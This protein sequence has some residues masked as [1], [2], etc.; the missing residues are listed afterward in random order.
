MG[1]S[2]VLD[3]YQHKD[4]YMKKLLVCLGISFALVACSPGATQ[5]AENS[6]QP[7]EATGTAQPVAVAA[8]DKPDSGKT[9]SDDANTAKLIDPSL[10]NET[11]PLT[12]HVLV[13]TT[14]G[15]MRFKIDRTWAPHGVDRFYN[16][17]KNGYFTDI[18]MFRMVPGFV[19]QFGIHG[20]PILNDVWREATI[21][22]DPANQTNADGTLTFANAGPNTRTTQM[23]FNIANNAALD[24]RGFPPIGKLVE[25]REVLDKLNYEYGEKPHQGMIQKKGNAYLKESFPNLDYILSITIEE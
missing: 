22:D 16:L 7:V 2:S 8:A 1:R 24:N 18:A 13:Q 10:L 3:R 4:G 14:K 17:V 6:A 23:F 19:V 5:K 9:A 25:G 21:P 11:A 12:F 15:N 20:K